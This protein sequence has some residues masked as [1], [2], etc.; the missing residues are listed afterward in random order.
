MTSQ[1]GKQTIAKHKDNQT[2]KLGQ[3]IEYNMKNVFLQKSCTKWD[4]KTITSPFS[5]K[6]KLSL[7][8]DQKSKDLYSLFLLYARLRAIKIC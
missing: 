4:G 5:K 1:P 3:L 8:L 7:S 6:S 2:V